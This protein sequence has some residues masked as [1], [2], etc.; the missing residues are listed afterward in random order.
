MSGQ[1]R[2]ITRK[3][4]CLPST[5]CNSFLHLSIRQSDLGIQDL[6]RS[7]LE[8]TRN[9]LTKS[10]NSP[11]WFVQHLIKSSW[12]TTELTRVQVLCTQYSS[13][14]WYR[15]NYN[16][17]N[18]THKTF[19]NGGTKFLNRYFTGAECLEGQR[20]YRFVQIRA[21]SDDHNTSPTATYLFKL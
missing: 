1:I 11:I 13:Q 19:A 5:T 14:Q 6:R 8:M 2:N 3:W 10:Q 9:R 21:F 20:F 17:I 12:Y 15:D 18:S 7:I 16:D 4:A